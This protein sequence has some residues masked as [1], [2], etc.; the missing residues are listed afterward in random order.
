M[1]G[2]TRV[3]KPTI[4]PD[5]VRWPAV[6]LNPVDHSELSMSVPFFNIINWAWDVA[7]GISAHYLFNWGHDDKYIESEIV[8]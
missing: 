7:E 5:I 8:G 1:T 4:R 3:V 2:K 6:I